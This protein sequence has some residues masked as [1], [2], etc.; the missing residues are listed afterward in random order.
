[1]GWVCGEVENKDQLNSTQLK[2]KL[3]FGA[4]LGNIHLTICPMSI[5]KGVCLYIFAL[6]IVCPIMLSYQSHFVM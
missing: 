4:E 2:L 5:G 3:P 1:M 6:F